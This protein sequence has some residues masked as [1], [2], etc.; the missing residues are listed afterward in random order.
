[1]SPALLLVLRPWNL[2]TCGI[3]ESPK[4]KKHHFN[5]FHALQSL[6]FVMQLLG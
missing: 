5:F 6:G 4:P 2:L 1:M 3:S